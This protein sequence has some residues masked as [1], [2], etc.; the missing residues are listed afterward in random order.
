MAVTPRPPDSRQRSTGWEGARQAERALREPAHGRGLEVDAE[1]L[2]SDLTNALA[3]DLEAM[4][5]FGVGNPSR[6]SVS[7]RSG[8][9]G[10]HVR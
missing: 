2:P 3:A 7:R 8:R 9:V 6:Y 1:L 5:P 4:S 10:A